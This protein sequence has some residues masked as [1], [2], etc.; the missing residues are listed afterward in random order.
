V[1]LAGGRESTEPMQC[2][3]LVD[4]LLCPQPVSGLQPR[5]GFV[6]WLV[7]LVGCLAGWLG[8]ER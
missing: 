8:T 2:A 1:R 4:S 5:N 3:S 6:G 7:H